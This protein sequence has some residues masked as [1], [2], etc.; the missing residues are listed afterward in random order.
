VQ[1]TPAP[2]KLPPVTLHW[3]SVMVTQVVLLVQQAPAAWALAVEV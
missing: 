1:A 2:R 3:Q